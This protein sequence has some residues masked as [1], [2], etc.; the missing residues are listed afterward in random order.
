MLTSLLHFF[1]NFGGE[2]V[3]EEHTEQN[4]PFLSTFYLLCLLE[5]NWPYEEANKL[6]IQRIWVCRVLVFL[7][8]K[9]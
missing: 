8:V 2:K 4:L 3:A 5:F 1:G 6:N 9:G 7:K